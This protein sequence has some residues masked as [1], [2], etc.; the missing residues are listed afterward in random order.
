M[1]PLP[2][3][4]WIRSSSHGRTVRVYHTDP[5]TC[6]NFPANHNPITLG[7]ADRR[8][9]VQCRICAGTER[10]G[11]IDGN[12]PRKYDG[13]VAKLQANDPDLPNPQI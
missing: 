13:L 3:P 7:E 12:D 5:V 1:M 9:L 11:D 10:R 2:L 8:G 4:L 6:E